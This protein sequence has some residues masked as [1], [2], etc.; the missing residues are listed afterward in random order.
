MADER[1]RVASFRV[2]GSRVQGFGVGV[3]A[4][5]AFALRFIMF[6]AS[7]AAAAQTLT[8]PDPSP[9]ANSPPPPATTITTTTT[10]TT[11]ECATTT[12]TR[13]TEMVI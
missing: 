2:W 8:P 3:W 5:G 4:F 7:I 1:F 11:T 9:A 6:M 12:T 13:S 10:T